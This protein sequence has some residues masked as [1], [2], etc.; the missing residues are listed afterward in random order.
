MRTRLLSLVSLPLLLSVFV[1]CGSDDDEKDRGTDSGGSSGPTSGPEGLAD[2]E[3]TT[4]LGCGFGFARADEEGETMLRIS[5]S[6]EAGELGRTVTFPAPGWDA[7]VEVGE[8]LT[9]NWCTDVIE[10][11]QRDVQETWQVVEGTL[12]FAGTV[13]TTD[14]ESIDEATAEL[15]DVVVVSEDGERVELDDLTLTNGSWGLFA[16]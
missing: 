15:T 1:A 7:V 12:T 8:H 11:P 13:P 9:A 5:V 14:S 16:G 10:E 6:Q 2:V 4:D 3:L